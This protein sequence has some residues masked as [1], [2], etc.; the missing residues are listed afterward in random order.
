MNVPHITEPIGVFAAYVTQREAFNRQPYLKRQAMIPDFMFHPRSIAARLA[1]MKCIHLTKS[2]FSHAAARMMNGAVERRAAKV[3]QEYTKKARK[4]DEQFNGCPLDGPPDPVLRKL[5][6]YGRVCPL[7]IGPF[8]EINADFDDLIVDLANFGAEGSW[9][10]MGA[11]SIKEARACNVAYLRRSIGICAT[12]QNAQIKERAL[13]MCV[14]GPQSHKE[15]AKRRAA[16]K[17]KADRWH[18]EYVRFKQ[19]NG[20]QNS[21]A[22]GG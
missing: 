16:S 1:E 20:A 12:R 14:G 9:R 5:Q 21:P 17:T 6:E 22:C 19:A 18:A 3:P 10:Q 4:A 7:V 11:R 15:A 13:G 8:A 2:H